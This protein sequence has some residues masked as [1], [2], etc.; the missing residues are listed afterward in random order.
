M[1]PVELQATP[2][3]AGA[4]PGLVVRLSRG[5]LFVLLFVIYIGGLPFFISFS[6]ALLYGNYVVYAICAVGILSFEWRAS[7]NLLSTVPYLGWLLIVYCCW[8]TLVAGADVSLSQ[9]VRLFVRNALVISL[10]ELAVVDRQGVAR[11]A[12]CFQIGALFNLAIALRELSDPGLVIKL[13]FMLDPNASSFSELRPA[14]LWSNPNEAAFSYIFAFFLSY[15]A[16]RPLAWIGRLGCLI[17]VCLTASRTGIY[18]LILC[19][20]IYLVL[21]LRSMLFN[22]RRLALLLLSGAVLAAAVAIFSGSSIPRSLDLSK[23]WQLNRILDFSEKRTLG[24]EDSSRLQ[25]AQEAIERA[26]E[27]PW[28][29]HGIFSFQGPSAFSTG[30]SLLSTGVH[31]VYIAVWGETGIPG[32]VSFLLLLAYGLRRLFNP[33]IARDERSILL[34]MWISYLVIGFTWHNQF[35]PFA[36]MLFIALLYHLPNVLGHYSKTAPVVGEELEEKVAC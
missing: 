31:N 9:V 23:Q 4:S 11:A 18:V 26:L 25:I 21:N 3:R 32:L 6:P 1:S 33:R 7:R 36:G 24:A 2:Y 28:T 10:F 8:G 30:S 19:S 29:G 16:R 22:Y 27:R 5:T 13:A 20:T 34:L 15:W 35:S 12:D 17:G 14:G